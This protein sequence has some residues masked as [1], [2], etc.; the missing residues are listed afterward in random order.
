MNEYDMLIRIL[1]RINVIHKVKDTFLCVRIDPEHDLDIRFL[2]GGLY[3]DAKVTKPGVWK[4]CEMC[5]KV[6]F[7]IAQG[8]HR[9]TRM[10]CSNACRVRSGELARK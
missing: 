1:G 3:Y 2:S 6:K 9:K 10:Y 5:G 4:S 8:V 7:K